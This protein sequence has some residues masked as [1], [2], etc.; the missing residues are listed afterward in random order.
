MK[1]SVKELSASLYNC[2]VE[3]RAGNQSSLPVI[4]G[5]IKYRYQ[6]RCGLL[7]S[8]LLGFS[9]Q[10]DLTEV[11]NPL[12]EDALSKAAFYLWEETSLE[13]PSLSIVL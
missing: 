6:A 11:I 1:G 9:P 8:S 12:D 13:L 7:Y 2:S 10:C 5:V 3:G 4:Y